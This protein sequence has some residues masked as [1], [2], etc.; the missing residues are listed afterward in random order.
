MQKLPKVL[1]Y[2][3]NKDQINQICL[4]NIKTLL[5]L[6]LVNYIDLFLA[7]KVVKHASLLQKLLKVLKYRPNKDQFDWIYLL[8]F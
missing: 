8:K 5:I 1:K 2:R 7:L 4:V 3:P 6:H